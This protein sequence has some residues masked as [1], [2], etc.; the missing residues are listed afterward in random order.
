MG[1]C[2]SNYMGTM[3]SDVLKEAM[4]DAI[5]ITGFGKQSTPISLSTGTEP[6]FAATSI[7]EKCQV[8]LVSIHTP[9]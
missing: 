6:E 3:S 7:L 9:S 1:T 8:P 4:E 5:R 2:H